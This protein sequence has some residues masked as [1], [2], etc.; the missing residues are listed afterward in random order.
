MNV[1]VTQPKQSGY[2]TVYPDGVTKPNASNLNFSARETVPNLV[3][4]PLTSGVADIANTSGGTV[5][6]VADLAGYFASGA[7]DGFV[8][9]G[10]Y[11]EVDSRTV[12]SP[13]TAH[14]TYTRQ[15][16]HRVRQLAHVRG[17]HGGQRD[18]HRPL[19][20]AC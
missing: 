14:E 9:F 2:L 17:R 7:P 18:G 4:V 15:H 13:I 3:I 8:P 16:P 10:P 19:R 11:R 6:V 1:T 5:Q 20:M 12:H